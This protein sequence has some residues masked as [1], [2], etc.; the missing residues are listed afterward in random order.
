[1]VGEYRTIAPPRQLVFTWTW[2]APDPYAGPVLMEMTGAGPREEPHRP[3]HFDFRNGKLWPNTR[4]GLGVEFD[5]RRAR[6]AAE[7]SERAAPIRLF[8]RPD[9]SIT[10]W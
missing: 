2:E 10:N 7:I 1:M 4:P 3:Q 6:L 8:R 9:G 5:P